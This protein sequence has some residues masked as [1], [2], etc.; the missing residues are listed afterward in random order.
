M[1]YELSVCRSDG[2]EEISARGREELSILLNFTSQITEL[3]H[4]ADREKMS[5]FIC[6]YSKAYKVMCRRKSFVLSEY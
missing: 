1:G 2:L 4:I 3:I 6:V 5:R